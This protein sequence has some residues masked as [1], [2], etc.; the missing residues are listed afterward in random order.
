VVDIRYHY[1]GTYF[2]VFYFFLIRLRQNVRKK[3]KNKREAM[4]A[5]DTVVTSGG[6]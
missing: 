6:I 5:G 4:K 3:S 2:V 1:D